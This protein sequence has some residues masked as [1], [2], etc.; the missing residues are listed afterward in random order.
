MHNFA[1]WLRTQ[2]HALPITGRQ[3]GDTVATYNTLCRWYK[4][5][6]PRARQLAKIADCIAQHSDRSIGDVYAEIH[7]VL[8]E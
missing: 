3:F 5:S 2:V 7:A 4:G 1:M 8:S 6:E